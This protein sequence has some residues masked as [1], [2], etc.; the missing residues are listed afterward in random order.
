MAQK[1]KED[2]SWDNL[3]AC[4]VDLLLC[5]IAEGFVGWFAVISLN[6]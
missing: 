5:S 6:A 1:T 2:E 4:S 3:R